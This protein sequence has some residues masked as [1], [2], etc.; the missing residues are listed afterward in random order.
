MTAAISTN[1]TLAVLHTHHFF[2]QSDGLLI[3]YAVFRVQVKGCNAH[4]REWKEQNCNPE[5]HIWTRVFSRAPCTNMILQRLHQGTKI[6]LSASDIPHQS[7][8]YRWTQPK[9]YHQPLI[10]VY[11]HLSL[12]SSYDNTPTSCVA[13]RH[14]PSWVMA[15]N[16][17]LLPWWASPAALVRL[18]LQKRRLRGD[19][20]TVYK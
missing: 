20:I 16:L 2:M 14:V 4:I 5:P 10:A 18:H 8:N 6:L 17:S 3:E 9:A 12:A 1:H 15:E 11:R 7:Q 13:V 19:L